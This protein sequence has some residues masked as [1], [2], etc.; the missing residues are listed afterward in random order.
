MSILADVLKKDALGL[1]ITDL[2]HKYQ[3]KT[4]L[5]IGSSDGT[6]STQ[7]FADAMGAECHLY[8][9]EMFDQ[10]FYKLQRNMAIH[11]NVHC[12][13]CASVD[14]IIKWD[15]VEKFR[16]VHPDFTMW[17]VMAE[18]EI[19]KWHDN[20]M[21]QVPT[22]E[23]PNGIE[24]IKKENNITLFDMVFIDGSPFTAMAELEQVYGAGIIIMDDTM[25]LKC[26]D[27][28]MVLLNDPNYEMI[29]RDDS[30]RNGYA[31]FKNKGYANS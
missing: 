25:D 10:R 8:C 14:K 29:A 27:T 21:A 31:V 23:I 30:Y 28:M 3:P 17:K 1:L 9:I 16:A 24:H 5:E 13:M 4:I 15:Y 20:T 22:M 12:Y 11:P 19:K 7:V 2:V 6:G 18:R 26:Y